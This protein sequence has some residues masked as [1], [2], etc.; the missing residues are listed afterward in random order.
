MKFISSSS[1]REEA[2]TLKSEIRN[3]SKP[4]H[5]GCYGS[6]GARRSRRFNARTQGG[7]GAG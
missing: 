7:A 2:Q 4:H 5:R 3:L 1:R 6:Q